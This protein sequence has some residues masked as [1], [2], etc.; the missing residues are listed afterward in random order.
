[1]VELSDSSQTLLELSFPRAAVA[2]RD[3]VGPWLARPLTQVREDEGPD[4]D[5]RPR[6]CHTGRRARSLLGVCVLI[7]DTTPPQR[8]VLGPGQGRARS[9]SRPSTNRESAPVSVRAHVLL[10]ELPVSASAPPS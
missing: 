8:G 9:R 10:A 1:M 7:G 6:P 3:F 5:G 2:P 4:S